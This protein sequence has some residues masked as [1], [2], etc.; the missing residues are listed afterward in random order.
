MAIDVSTLASSGQATFDL[1]FSDLQKRG[2]PDDIYATRVATAESFKANEYE[3]VALYGQE[4]FDRWYTTTL[5]YY[6]KLQYDPNAPKSTFNEET[7]TMLFN[8]LVT[9]DMGPTFYRMDDTL[10]QGLMVYF[11][12]RNATMRK[13]PYQQL[14]ISEELEIHPPIR[15]LPNEIPF[16]LRMVDS[17]FVPRTIALSSGPYI[18]GLRLSPNPDSI[19]INSAKVINRY[20]TMTR[21]VEDHWGDEI[22][23]LSITGSSFS[24]FGYQLQGKTPGLVSDARNVTDAYTYLQQL[25]SLFTAGG[26]LIQDNK[27]YSGDIGSLQNNY[28]MIGRASEEFLLDKGNSSF[29]NNHPREG[30]V[31]ERL[32]MNLEFDYLSCFGYLDTFD[33]AEASGTPYRMTY[34]LVFKSEKTVY[35][36]GSITRA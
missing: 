32:Y 13:V 29:L 15:R 27:I 17:N 2:Y 19:A 35:R 24:F 5:D 22:D 33:I 12:E 30:L 4:A 16:F 26:F 20:Q 18:Q 6:S 21:W 10:V 9:P 36:Q 1:W 3:L 25:S 11:D 8:D 31:K 28:D 14:G 7:G 34:T 23:V